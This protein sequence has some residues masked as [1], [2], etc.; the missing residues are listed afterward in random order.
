MV[1]NVFPCFGR[2]AIVDDK[3]EEVRQIQNILAEKG[4]PY[5]FYDYQDMHEL[6]INKVDGIRI[7]FLDIR[8]ED[9]T[10]EEKNLLTVLA[11]TVER[12]IPI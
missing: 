8:L 11:S 1:E 4:V 3:R 7:L 12:I 6:E 2:V 9:G 5:I 10:S